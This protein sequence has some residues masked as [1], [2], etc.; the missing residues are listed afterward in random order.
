MGGVIH[1][2]LEFLVEK[3]GKKWINRG[4]SFPQKESTRGGECGKLLE[5]S[6]KLRYNSN[7]LKI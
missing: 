3:V 2:F 7:R 4:G 6:G 1:S 5:K